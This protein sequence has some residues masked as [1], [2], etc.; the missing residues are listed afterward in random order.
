MYD[1]TRLLGFDVASVMRLSNGFLVFMLGCFLLSGVSVL[2]LCDRGLV[3]LSFDDP[4]LLAV[5]VTR[6]VD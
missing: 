2:V 6:G 1:C 3:L 5:S 4:F